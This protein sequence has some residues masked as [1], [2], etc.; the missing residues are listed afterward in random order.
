MNSNVYTM[1]AVI[2]ITVTNPL[3]P[4]GFVI[5]YICVHVQA[6]LDAH[7]SVFQLLS[8]SASQF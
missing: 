4:C 3:S 6:K 8:T 5:H 7:V 2:L 1:V